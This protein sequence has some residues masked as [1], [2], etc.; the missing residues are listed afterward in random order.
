MTQRPFRDAPDHA[1]CDAAT[2]G[3]RGDGPGKRCGVTLVSPVTD[4]AN[5][6]SRFLRDQN[7]MIVL[8]EDFAKPRAMLIKGDWL[9]VVAISSRF[10]IV[11]PLKE[12]GC[13]VKSRGSES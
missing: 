12:E 7:D 10:R 4:G 13:I 6:N 1:C 11:S 3:V 9:C 2:P 8:R 5:G